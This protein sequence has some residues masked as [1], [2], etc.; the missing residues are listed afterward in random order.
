[1][2]PRVLQR[3]ACPIDMIEETGET[4]TL[5]IV[6]EIKL[7]KLEDLYIVQIKQDVDFSL[8]PI[9]IGRFRRQ[10]ESDLNG[11]HFCLVVHSS[12]IR[13]FRLRKV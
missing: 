8:S 5:P 1:M 12:P 13:F 2:T 11:R 7:Q 6:G 9:Q 4:V 3:L 10:L